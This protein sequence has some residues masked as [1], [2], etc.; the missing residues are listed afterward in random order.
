MEAVVLV[1]LVGRHG[2]GRPRELDLKRKPTLDTLKYAPPVLYIVSI[3][4]LRRRGP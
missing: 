4:C 3:R 2:R 1:A